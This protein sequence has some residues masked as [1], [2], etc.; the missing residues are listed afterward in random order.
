M[1]WDYIPFND[2]GIT[3]Y[4][5]FKLYPFL[6]FG[7]SETLKNRIDQQIRQ[8][9]G[10]HYFSER[11]IIIGERG[12]GKTSAL[13]FIKDQLEKSNINVELF[14][15]LI[16]DS[17]HFKTITGK[18]LSSLSEKP[19]YI[20]IDFPDTLDNRGFKRFLEFLWSLMTH[21]NYNKIN[22][23]FSM[24]KSHF[25]KSFNFSEIFGKFLTLRLE[26]LDL[27]QT[28]Q[29]IKSRLKLLNQ[30]RD[31][32]FDD[33]VLEMVF[34]YSKGVPRNIISACSLLVDDSD[35]G[36]ITKTIAE[37]VL[38]EKYVDQ[39][40]DDRI[41]DLELKRIYKQM[42]LVLEKEFNGI[43]KSQED[44]VKRVMELSGIGRNSVLARINDL[45]KFGI[46]VQYRGG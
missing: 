15:R 30:K 10:E 8:I 16:E 6:V 1:N 21:K 44:Y 45:T 11:S 18:F 20:L 29:L 2:S 17:D 46:F 40:I 4:E 38:K 35:N 34:N 31:N 19:L 3:N 26:R 28:E 23:I 43:A 41:Q 13:F 32:L 24:N 9:K 22:L 12:I 36:K 7:T 39:I 37:K 42:V 25:E 5:Q 27:T 14:T 33:E